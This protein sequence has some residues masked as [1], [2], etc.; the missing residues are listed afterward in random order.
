[1]LFMILI[2]HLIAVIATIKSPFMQLLASGL[3]IHIAL[4]VIINIFMVT[5]LLPIVGIPLPFISYGL[6]NLW[7]TFASMGWF[8]SIALARSYRN[9]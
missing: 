6:S 2:I 7:V 1:M 5:G 9:E 4:A 8:N 3:I